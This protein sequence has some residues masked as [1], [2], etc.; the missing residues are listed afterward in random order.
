MKIG[1]FWKTTSFSDGHCNSNSLGSLLV[2]WDFLHKQWG[3]SKQRLATG[4]YTLNDMSRTRKFQFEPSHGELSPI[5]CPWGSGPSGA[6]SIR[7]DGPKIENL[8]WKPYI[9]SIFCFLK[10][11]M[12]CN[13][14]SLLSKNKSIL[15]QISPKL[16]SGQI[17]S[18]YSQ[19]LFKNQFQVEF[20]T[21]FSFS[22]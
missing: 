3:R 5:S 4:A 20:G 2:G 9:P 15:W 13:F 14:L 18:S 22:S 1:I 8:L 6:H 19:K 21:T 17:F 11:K 10:K 7:S 16:V 12:C